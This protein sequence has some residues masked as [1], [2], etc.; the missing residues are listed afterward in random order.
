MQ[1]EL[2]EGYTR[3]EEEEEEELMPVIDLSHLL[4]HFRVKIISVYFSS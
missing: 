2:T 1:I 3:K 4:L